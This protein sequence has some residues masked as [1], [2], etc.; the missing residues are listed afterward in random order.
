MDNLL[1]QL[2]GLLTRKRSKK[3]YAEKLGITEEEVS[4][5]M[6]EL[7]KDERDYHPEVPAQLAQYPL[8]PEEC[9]QKEVN[10]EK[11][12]LKSTTETT[13]EPRTDE[14]LAEL[15]KIDTEKYKITNYW[16]KRLPNGKFTS[17]VFCTLI[18]LDDSLLKQKDHLI[19]EISN[20]ERPDSFEFTYN[21]VEDGN[22]LEISIPDMHIGKLSHKSE[23]NED[24]DLK[25]AV[26]RYKD[27]VQEIL[28]RTNLEKVERIL[29]PIG[30]DLINIDNENLTTVA[31]T[32]QDCDS[33]FSK[34]V[35]VTK[36]L[37]I[38][39]INQLAEIAPVDVVIVKGNHDSTVTFMIGEILDAWFHQ[40]R[41][42]TIDNSPKWR[43]Y[44][45]YGKVG[46]LYTH[47]EKEKVNDLGLIFATEE[48]KLWADT[49]YRFAKL[50][51][52]H[53]SKEMKHVSVDT[54]VGFQVQILPSLS[55]TDEWHYGKGYLGLKQCKGYLYHKTKGE[56][57][58]Y[59]HTV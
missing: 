9:Y 12:T 23:T 32:P 30:N 48:A 53:K 40:N 10:N 21:K 3:Y 55:A 13:F 52:W 36:E 37:L 5:L 38:D 39:T 26:K 47:G 59:T 25:I 18:K 7:K 57:A 41:N 22:L 11:G 15:H 1:E 24:Y 45:Q 20:Y 8:T 16:S 28:S 31:G 58:Q 50:G 56:I 46:I 4:E 2:Q 19:T 44:Y 35:K 34:M 27:A 17:S 43:K 14:E 51:H 49:K 42:I 33:R 29:L 6:K 54:E